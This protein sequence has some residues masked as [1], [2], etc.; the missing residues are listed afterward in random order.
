M[1][2]KFSKT[3]KSSRQARKQRK[4]RYCAPL[5]IRHN[6]MSCNL[7]KELRVKYKR[8]SFPLRKGD[9]V[10]VRKGEFKKKKAKVADVDLIKTRVFL[11]GIQKTKKDGTKF[12]VPFRPWNLQIVELNLED[13]ER[14]KALER[15][16][17]KEK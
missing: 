11:E 15:K 13:K 3:W 6:F 8:R 7:S 2:K 17:R 4:Y 1:R 9:I 5:H 12:F 10:V 14:I 16:I